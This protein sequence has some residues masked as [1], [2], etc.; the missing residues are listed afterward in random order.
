MKENL[1]LLCLFVSILIIIFAQS[2]SMTTVKQYTYLA[3]GDSYTIGEGIPVFQNFP[4]QA[5]QLLR[6]KGV[7]MN[8]PDILAQTGWT[9]NELLHGMDQYA[10]QKNGYDF[11]TLLIGVNNQ[12][13]G[14]PA[15]TYRY[16]FEALLRQAIQFARKSPQHVIVLSIPDWSVTPFA[17]DS[18]RSR[19][20]AEIDAFNR[21]NQKITQEYNAHYL[22]ITPGS[23]DAAGDP[24]LI[25]GD[26]LH[27]SAHEYAKWARPLSE[28]ILHQL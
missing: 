13:R 9:T 7:D 3:L 21:I 15:E 4:N 20:G 27:P 18:D 10:F 23:R 16:E 22:D 17:A 6:K 12:Y 8:A 26:G 24:A 19:I 5:I 25:T 14:L 28:L 1:I 2:K 11:V